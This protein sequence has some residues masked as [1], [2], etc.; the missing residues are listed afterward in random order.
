M[1]EAFYGLNEKPFNLTPDP[2]YLY[3]SE[4][5]KEAFAHL[6]FGIKNRSGF[7]MVTGEIGTGKTTICRNLLNQ[8]DEETRL[9][10]V[11]N[12]SL[13]PVELLKHI[14]AEFG[15]QT[16]AETVLDL[17][18]AL[19]RYL[20]QAAGEGKRCV[21]VID[22]AQNLTPPVLEQI[23]LLSNLE[24]ETEKLLQIILIGQPELVERLELRELRQLNQRITARYHLRPLNEKETLQYI[25]YRLH[26]AGGRRKVRF[27]KPAIHAVYK[28]SGG[29]PRVINAICDRALLIGYTKEAHTITKA[30][31]QRAAQEIRGEKIARRKRQRRER[32]QWMP[33]PSFVVALL[34]SVA[35]VYYLARPIQQF[36][37]QLGVFNALLTQET[38]PAQDFPE[39][40]NKASARATTPAE[41]SPAREAA[42]VLVESA[43]AR[44]VLERLSVPEVAAPRPGKG[45]T[46]LAEELT[47]MDADTA[48]KAAAAALLRAWSLAAVSDYPEVDEPEA[49]EAF[50]ESNGLDYETIEPALDQLL[51]INRPAFVKMRQGQDTYWLAL[52]GVDG[53]DFTLS[54]GQGE[55]LEVPREIFKDHY[56]GKA[57]VPWRD[58]NPEAP[59]LLQGRRGRR[60]A[61]LKRVLRALGR[62]KTG[63]TSDRYGMDTARAV[64][65]IQ[66]ETGMLVDGIAGR[67]VRMVLSGWQG[68]NANPVLR[69]VEIDLAA[70]PAPE[71]ASTPPERAAADE[72]AEDSGE[73]DA[74]EGPDAV[75]AP[76]ESE[77]Q[78][79]A[80]ETGEAPASPSGDEVAETAAPGP[81]PEAESL[82]QVEELP[83]P[84]GDAELPPVDSP[85]L[86]ERTP[87]AT[88]A[89]LV[90]HT[91]QDGGI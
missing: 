77:A 7:V 82:V 67:Q 88:T 18:D 15:V 53:M 65:R 3:L 91:E 21:L 60:V 27:A 10:F 37:H 36:A 39:E 12:P 46:A 43:V 80:P 63:N 51:A 45:D 85:A 6:L 71:P 58:T 47:Q 48:R 72:T 22:E 34:L 11:F 90:P 73:S 35:L 49:L 30:I 89:P 52:L 84:G 83:E 19:N 31:V 75:E 61:E 54:T 44:R 81:P 32:K 9:A 79:S 66:A 68:D 74:Q 1:Y 50:L 64:A 41:P 57:I 8:L 62:L 42:D 38:L 4:K 56:A 78:P 17:T 76:E 25:A 16:N 14:N 33:S 29:T 59:D 20:L 2:K 86:K 55:T 40:E 70:A 69:P 24:T 26:V 13:N 5:H 23:R 28:Q 87:P